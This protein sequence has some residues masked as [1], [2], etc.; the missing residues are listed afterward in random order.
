MLP[1][2]F[3]VPAFCLIVL[4]L[5]L[6][7]LYFIV[8]IRIE[9]PVLALV[10]AFA[11]TKFLAVYKTNVADELILLCLILGLALL[12]FSRDKNENKT[13][14]ALRIKALIYTVLIDIFLAVFSIL[15][16]YGA[17]FMVFI[18]ANLILPFII[19]L[20]IFNILKYKTVTG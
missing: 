9:L 6:A 10:S 20:A 2:K 19:Y 12:A 3:K 4:G 14:S 16:I 1:H 8:N 17:G 11:E 5:V 18:I 15:F 13:F 7:Y